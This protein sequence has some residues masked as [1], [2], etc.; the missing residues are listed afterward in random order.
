MSALTH[1]GAQ[2][3]VNMVD[4]GEKAETTSGAATPKAIVQ[5]V[6]AWSGSGVSCL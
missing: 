4:V 3:E 1:L 6:V 2:G 5:H